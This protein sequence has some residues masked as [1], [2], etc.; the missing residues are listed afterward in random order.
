MAKRRAE[1]LT[2]QEHNSLIRMSD[3]LELANV[4]RIQALGE[5]SKH[6]NLSLEAT[7][8]KLGIESPDYD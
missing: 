2:E 1:T 7:M 3:R 6:W 5:L 4:K 8:E